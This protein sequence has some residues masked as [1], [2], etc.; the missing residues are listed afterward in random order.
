[1]KLRR[2]KILAIGAHPDDIEFGVGGLLSRYKNKVDIT[3]LVF[4]K[5]EES[6][7]KPFVR[8]REA[9]KVA[10]Y[11][12]AKLLFAGYYDTKIPLSKETI[13]TVENHIKTEKPDYIFVHYFEDTHQDHRNVSQ[14]TITAT[15]Y[16]RNVLFFEGPTTYN[17]HPTVFVD[18]TEFIDEK[19][20]LLKLHRSQVYRTKVEKL[21]IIE[22]AKS[23][24]VFRGYQMRVKYAE[25]F[26]PLRF[27]L[28]IE[29]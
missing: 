23:T 15:R 6:G 13:D 9:K 11:L 17:F 2:K 28:K 16:H 27:T 19:I 8:V 21:S 24:A 5:G 4:S 29:V 7:V 10:E 26:L 18:I 25:G 14:A 3:M 20:Q 12:N 1:M 22:S